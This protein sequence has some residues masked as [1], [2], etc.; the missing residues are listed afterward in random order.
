MT[1]RSGEWLFNRYQLE[2]RIGR[3]AMGEVYRA[4]DFRLGGVT[5][6][7]KFLSQTLQSSELRDRFLREAIIS[8]KLSN[9]ASSYIVSVSDYGRDHIST[10]FY[11]MQ[12][13]E[14]ISLSDR[15]RP[16]LSLPDFLNLSQQICLGLQCAHEGVQI[17]KNEPRCPVIHCDLK[18]SNIFVISEPRQGESIR[19]LDFG[20]ASLFTT[21]SNQEQGFQGGTPPYCS[22]EQLRGEILAPQSDLYSLGIVMFEMLTGRLPFRASTLAEWKRLHCTTPPPALTQVAPNR[23]FPQPLEQLIQK[24]LAKNPGDRPQSAQEIYEELRKLETQYGIQHPPVY[25]Q[26][27]SIPEPSVQPP[28]IIPLKKQSRSPKLLTWQGPVERGRIIAQ[29]L[30]EKQESLTS[31]WCMLPQTL[32]RSIQIHAEDNELFIHPLFVN[33]PHPM[34]LWVTRISTPGR[35]PVCIPYFLDLHQPRTL[36]LAQRLAE[37]G[38]YQVL[39]FDFEPPHSCSHT[40]SLELSDTHR[41]WLKSKLIES[42]TLPSGSA[43]ESRRLL[44]E[45]YERLRQ[46][47]GCSDL[48]E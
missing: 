4:E 37:K 38:F 16:Y 1:D 2:K 3:G 27:Q 9:K 32:I 29:P 47:I 48:T 36:Y 40:L 30:F 17:D 45:E 6:A 35:S 14:G 33:R 23:T 39:L 12:Y 46:Q 24:C 5:V 26:H 41:R 7:I 34:L 11:V 25:P 8:A 28:P 43:R 18:P 20:I 42:L 21:Q 10:P 19:I 13:L 22:P 44:L 31:F 15:L